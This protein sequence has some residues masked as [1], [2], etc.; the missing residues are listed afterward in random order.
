MRFAA[1]AREKIG[2]LA[3]SI[4]ATWPMS[5]ASYVSYTV[6]MVANPVKSMETNRGGQI[7]CKRSR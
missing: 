3:Y 2:Y 6:S 7:G 1:S 5:K 4:P